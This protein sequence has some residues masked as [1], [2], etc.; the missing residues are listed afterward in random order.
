MCVGSIKLKNSPQK[1]VFLFCLFI[2]ETKLKNK[3]KPTDKVC[4][5]TS[6]QIKNVSQNSTAL[7]V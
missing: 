7:T 6:V 4:E 3:I 2:T 1:I 5:A